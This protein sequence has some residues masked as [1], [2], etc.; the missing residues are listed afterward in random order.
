MESDNILKTEVCDVTGK[1]LG[2]FSGNQ[3]DLSNLSNGLYILKIYSKEG[4]LQKEKI[5]L[6]R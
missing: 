6:A 3:I 2:L 1:S 4:L 5:M